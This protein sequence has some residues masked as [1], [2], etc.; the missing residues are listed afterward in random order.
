MSGKYLQQTTSADNVF[1]CFLER[2]EAENLKQSKDMS[3]DMKFYNNVACATSKGSDQ[4][5]HTLV[6]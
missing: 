6:A 5:A 4:P 1:I 2:F 3:R